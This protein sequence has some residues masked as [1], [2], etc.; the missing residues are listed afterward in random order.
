MSDKARK[1]L[2]HLKQLET[3]SS[4]P[5]SFNI[6]RLPVVDICRIINQEDQTV[7]GAVAEQIP[8][9][10]RTAEEVANVIRNGGQIFYIGAGTSGRLGV[11]DAAEIPPTFGA[12]P[13]LFTGVIAGGRDTLVLSKEGVEDETE[14][15]KI[16]LVKF[17]F[18]KD[19]MLIG[20]AASIKTP[21][22]I[23]GIEYAKS[24]GAATAFIICNN[25]NSLEIKPDFLIQLIVGPEVITGSTRMKSGTAQK[26]TLNMISTAAMVLLGKCYGNLMVDLK[27][28]SNKLK[29][30]SR[31]ILIELLDIDYDQA[32]KLLEASSGSVKVAIAMQ[33]LGIDKSEAKKQLEKS[34]GYLWKLLEE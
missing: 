33:T 7:A 23:A 15:A 34:G 8:Q 13:S 18:S 24:V 1:L 22:T 32:D 5:K 2:G 21:Y 9:I 25:A 12:D 4:N 20:L 11:L 26:M 17:N 6:D 28:T 27:A 3:E 14:Q 10:A 29:A 16:D 31:K 30:R 19:D